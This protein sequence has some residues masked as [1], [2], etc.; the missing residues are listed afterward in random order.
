MKTCEIMV[1][2]DVILIPQGLNIMGLI[3]KQNMEPK[4]VAVVC[5]GHVVPRVHWQERLCE[6]TDNIEIFSVVAGG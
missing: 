1:N 5:N 4:S 2:D 6:E 3:T